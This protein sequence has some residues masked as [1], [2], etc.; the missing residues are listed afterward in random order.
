MNLSLT[1]WLLLIFSGVF[2]LVI[3][4]TLIVFV[5]RI[6]REAQPQKSHR[7]EAGGGP[8]KKH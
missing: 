7:G 6:F 3:L 5:I 4:F 8:R 2:T 1:G